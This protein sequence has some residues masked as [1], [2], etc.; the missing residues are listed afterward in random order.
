MRFL[1][2]IIAQRM[3]MAHGL[4]LAL[5][6]VVSPALF[7]AE[8]LQQNLYPTGGGHFAVTLSPCKD[9]VPFLNGYLT[10]NTGTNWLYVEIQVKVT[11]G[12]ATET[13]R[14][15]LERVGANGRAI[16][17][18][19]ENAANQDCESIRLC[20]LELIA[21]HSEERAAGARQKR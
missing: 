13:Y 9:K 18:V 14:F 2:L 12:N 3:A 7:G 1:P 15:N 6:L 4:V 8:S 19:I 11:R 21:A 17:Q 10:N 16:R 5:S 20:H